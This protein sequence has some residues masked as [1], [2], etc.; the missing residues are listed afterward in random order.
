MDGSD[1]PSVVVGLVDAASYQEAVFGGRS[2]HRHGRLCRVGASSRIEASIV[3][4]V[5]LHQRP[6][7]YFVVAEVGDLHNMHLAQDRF[8]QQVAASQVAGSTPDDFVA[9]DEPPSRVLLKI[10]G[11]PVAFS[12][13]TSVLPDTD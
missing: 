2:A 12:L 9:R 1:V 10:G 4:P 3:D 8:E 13:H 7:A 6:V 11:R 5:H